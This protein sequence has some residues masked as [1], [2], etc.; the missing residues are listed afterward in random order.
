M[1]HWRI[2]YIPKRVVIKYA[3]QRIS[4]GR[5]R[6]ICSHTP[7]TPTALCRRIFKDEDIYDNPPRARSRVAFFIFILPLSASF[8]GCSAAIYDSRLHSTASA[9]A[10]AAGG[11]LMYIP[12][13]ILHAS[14]SLLTVLSD[15]SSSSS[16]FLL[17]LLRGTRIN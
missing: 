4:S 7:T 8:K 9:A 15:C 14:V 6:V 1:V 2:D 17:L 11:W 12:T 10:A 3:V 13:T 16:E 5:Q